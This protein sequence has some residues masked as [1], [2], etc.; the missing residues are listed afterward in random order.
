MYSLSTEQDGAGTTC[1]L[2]TPYFWENDSLQM[3]GEKIQPD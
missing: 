3:A 2:N 1:N